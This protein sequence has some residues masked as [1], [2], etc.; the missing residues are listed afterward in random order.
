MYWKV[1]TGRDWVPC[2][3]HPKV[4]L[5]QFRALWPG[6]IPCLAPFACFLLF[7]SPFITHAS[8]ISIWSSLINW[9]GLI[10]ACAGAHVSNTQNSDVCMQPNMILSRTRPTTKTTKKI[11][12]CIFSSGLFDM[13]PRGVPAP[14]SCNS[15]CLIHL[16][17]FSP[18]PRRANSPLSLGSQEMR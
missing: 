17:Q 16:A 9:D 10:H 6:L 13:E 12:K 4:H 3:W 11:A 15:R 8:G 2:W 5:A 14:S 18:G 1:E 7:L